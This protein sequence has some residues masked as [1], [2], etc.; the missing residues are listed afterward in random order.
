MKKAIVTSILI[1]VALIGSAQKKH[2]YRATSEFVT[3]DGCTHQQAMW[4]MDSN[5]A[6]ETGYQT[7]KKEISKYIK[8]YKLVKRSFRVTG[9][10]EITYAAFKKL[11]ADKFE[12]CKKVESVFTPGISMNAPTYQH[13]YDFIYLSPVGALI[14]ISPPDSL[15]IV[16]MKI[17]G[18]TKLNDSTFTFKKQ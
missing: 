9:I 16:T 6:I 18:L 12:P 1:L 17:H 13:V 7:F 14:S 10:E 4:W 8:P 15:N 3:S 5:G 11:K 2:Y